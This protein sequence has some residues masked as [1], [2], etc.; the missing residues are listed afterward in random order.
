MKKAPLT[1]AVLVPP[2]FERK[3]SG[4]NFV[5]LGLIFFVSIFFY[6]CKKSLQDSEAIT[7]ELQN[8]SSIK[9]TEVGNIGINVVLTTGITESI[10]EELKVYGKII[11]TFPEIKALTMLTT[12]AKLS[13]IKVLPYVSAA[14]PDAERQGSPVDNLSLD[15]FTGGMS[16]WDLDALNVTDYGVGRTVQPD[17][18]G[19][20]IGILD[21]GLPDNWRQLFPEERIATQYA[22]SFGGGGN[23]AGR[24]SEQP[25][26]W[27]H[28]QNS[29][30]GHVTST[31][32]GYQFRGI[33]VNGVAPKAT[34]IPVKILG[35][36]GWGWS[37]VISEGILYIASL[38]AGV[39]HNSP[40]LINMSLGGS[41]LDALEKAA[42]DYAISQ[43]V[44]I[45]AAAGNSGS[46]GMTYPGGYAPVISVAAA[47]WYGEFTAT[48]WAFSLDVPDPTISGNYYIAAFSSRRLPGQDLDVAAPGVFVIGP[49]QVNSGQTAYYYLSGTSMASP[50]VAGVVALMAQ[51]KST[52][53]AAEAES[54]LE[55]TALPMSAGP[56]SAGSGFVTAN[57]ALAAIP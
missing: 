36:N 23:D 24:V 12:N 8:I 34:V 47:G 15:N 56:N 57:A 14:S 40:V 54:I 9:S 3:L 13:R 18:S 38:K 32:L 51:K 5:Q 17:G 2:F 11:N 6:S 41:G 28:D 50:H 35:Q 7:P 37:S 48:D 43:G 16:S 27:E 49:Y 30:G 20:F 10:L 44:I 21:T 45:V 26:K 22:K 52:L 19:V 33:S 53:T 1:N 55:S 46:F 42:I 29:H 4:I 31:I 39:L 25:N